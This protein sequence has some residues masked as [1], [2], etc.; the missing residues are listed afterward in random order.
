M[1]RDR[2]CEKIS[3]SEKN[4]QITIPHV[5]YASDDK[6]AEIVGVSL[7]SLYENSQDVDDIF[8]YILD[9]G[10]C[11]KNKKRIVEV[12]KTYQRHK[13]I[14][15]SAKNISEELS[16]NV[17]VD[18]GSLSQYAR[19][20]VSSDLP[21]DLN[22]VIYLDCDIIVNKSISLLWNLDMHEKTIAAL[23]DAFSKHYRVNIDLKPNDIMFNSGVMLIDLHKWKQNE[24]EKKLMSF[25]LKKNGKIQQGDQGA[26]NSIL[27][28]DVYCFHPKFNSVTIFYDFTYSEMLTYRKPPYFYK[29]EETRV[30]IEQPVIIH[31]TSSI[32]SKRPWEVGCCHKY[33]DKWIYYK[34]RSPWK[35]EPLW[36]YER[37]KWKIWGINVIEFFPRWISIRFASFLQIY[38]RPIFMRIRNCYKKKKKIIRESE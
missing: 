9:S 25:I 30:A 13:P 4:H 35:Q 26:L 7:V 29:E 19:L 32:F 14:F 22:R 3:S 38:G 37:P 33:L 10:I 17:S 1:N 21:S 15:I 31:F 8:V 23:M 11:E 27:S 5:V 12:S 34:S 24:T 16:I 6:F 28:K 36:N 20:F 2:V 18:R